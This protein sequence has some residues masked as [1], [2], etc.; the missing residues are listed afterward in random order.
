MF[1]HFGLRSHCLRICLVLDFSQNS[2]SARNTKIK[3][4]QGKL[5]LHFFFMSCFILFLRGSDYSVLDTTAQLTEGRSVRNQ[6][7]QPT[8][9][10][11]RAKCFF[12]AVCCL[13]AMKVAGGA[14]ELPDFLSFELNCKN[15]HQIKHQYINADKTSVRD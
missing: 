2:A 13:H 3:G 9:K 12:F 14:L 6:L 1:H 11:D 5:L 15:I 7:K 4:E 10:K 8:K